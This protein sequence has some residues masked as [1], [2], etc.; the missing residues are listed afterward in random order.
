MQVLSIVERFFLASHDAGLGLGATFVIGVPGRL[1]RARVVE[2]WD[3]LSQRYPI[4]RSLLARRSWRRDGWSGF[5]WK[6]RFDRKIEPRFEPSSPRYVRSA[7]LHEVLD[8]ELERL[9]NEPHDLDR[10]PPV[11]LVVVE[12]GDLG[13]GL[14][15]RIHHAALDGIALAVLSQDLAEILDAMARG[16]RPS[17]EQ[18]RIAPRGMARCF[19]A[20]GLRGLGA[21]WLAH[22]RVARW[23]RPPRHDALPVAWSE[24]GVTTFGVKRVLP[25]ATLDAI[26][27]AGR[28][29]RISVNDVVLAAVARACVDFAARRDVRLRKV[30]LSVP[31]NLRAYL[32]LDPRE[33]IANQGVAV[34]IHVPASTVDSRDELLGAIRAQTVPLK[35]TPLPLITLARTMMIFALPYSWVVASLRRVLAMRRAPGTTPTL[36]VSNVGP[37]WQRPEGGS[38]DRIGALPIVYLRHLYQCGYPMPATLA[39]Y[40]YRNEVQMEMS[41]AAGG[42]ARSEAEGFLGLVKR[43]LFELLA[44]ED[45]DG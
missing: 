29:Q 7:P 26:R 6:E 35:A 1:D 14:V 44:I 42:L 24:R 5:A 27:A 23:N 19:T 22:A 43:Q 30:T 41:F 17:R 20:V 11:Q 39:L 12:H 18:L 34:E 2:A 21:A 9:G 8:A 15:I 28:R 4:L 25:A 36:T 37:I 13:T 16:E 31:M 3:I 10:E 40:T 33:S 45:P 38:V 32:R